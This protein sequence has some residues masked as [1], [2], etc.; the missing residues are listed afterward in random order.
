MLFGL[1]IDRV[2]IDLYALWVKSE[3]LL[4]YPRHEWMCGGRGVLWSSSHR[5]L[6]ITNLIWRTKTTFSL[7]EST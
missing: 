7:T 2:M 4:P 1:F 6:R 5:A 3:I